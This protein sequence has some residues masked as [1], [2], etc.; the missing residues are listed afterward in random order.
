MIRDMQKPS[1]TQKFL[2]RLGRPAFNGLAALAE[3]RHDVSL[4]KAKKAQ[5]SSNPNHNL[6]GLWLEVLNYADSQ[7]QS[8]VNR[9]V[10]V[11]VEK[12]WDIHSP[13]QAEQ[14][15]RESFAELIAIRNDYELPLVCQS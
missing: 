8:Q 5:E 11:I 3:C 14:V 7:Q 9:L 15:I 1:A 12:D 10:P 4:E 13:A 2:M 6:A